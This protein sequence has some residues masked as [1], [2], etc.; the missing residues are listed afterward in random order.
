L[1][2]LIV[3]PSLSNDDRDDCRHL[4]CAKSVLQRVLVG[5]GG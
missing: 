3:T 2:S 5:Y 1:L 4:F